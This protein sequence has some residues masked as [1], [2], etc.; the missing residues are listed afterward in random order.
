[1]KSRF[2]VAYIDEG[3]PYGTA[4][5]LRWSCQRRFAGLRREEFLVHVVVVGCGRVGSALAL[6][7]VESGHTV[8]VIDKRAEAFARLGPSF[9]GKT[10]T[11]IGFD[12]DRLIEAGIRDAA[13]VA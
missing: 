4:T 7:L 13:A 10:L 8:A 5:M 3:R 1:M 9:S 2:S 12:R 11:G 6:N